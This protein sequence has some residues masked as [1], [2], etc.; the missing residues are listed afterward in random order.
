MEVRIS[1][2]QDASACFL[3]SS[4]ESDAPIANS[5]L[6]RRRF[7]SGGALTGA[8]FAAAFAATPSHAFAR[9][10]PARAQPPHRDCIIEA[11]W[12]LAYVDGKLTLIPDASVRVR[13]DRIAEV[14]SGR[15]AGRTRR[16]HAHS[17]VTARFHLWP[18]ACML[19][20][21]NARVDRKR[22]LVCTS[23]R[24]RRIAD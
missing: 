15:I 6:T 23:A 17:I 2:L 19:G 22:T 9:K 3:C 1:N 11:S 8:T 4:E 24:N 5:N 14:K 13:G 10:T 7:L 21:A 12:V 18:H 20:H 16:V